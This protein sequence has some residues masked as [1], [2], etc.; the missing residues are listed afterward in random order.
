MMPLI[1]FVT[2]LSM[3]LIAGGQLQAGEPVARSDRD[4]FARAMTMLADSR[5]YS[6]RFVQE[7]RFAEGGST[8]YSGT[9]QLRRPGMFLWRYIKPYEQLYVSDGRVIWHYEPD[10][11]QAEKMSG[12]D[13]VDPA[14]MKL[15]DGRLGVDQIAL[16][17]VDHSNEDGTVYRI[18]LADGP[19]LLIAFTDDGLVRWLE[20]SDMLGNRNRMMLTR[21]SRSVPSEKSFRFVPPAGVD[22]VDLTGK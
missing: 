17:G 10:L 11:Q 6:C 15:L 9:L 4:A 13:V 19:E 20:S 14:A 1:R 2:L 22:V 7:L 5:G 8:L 3:V 16:L 12:L 18:R 21:M